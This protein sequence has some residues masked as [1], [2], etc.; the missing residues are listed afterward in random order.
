M[1]RKQYL[2]TLPNVTSDAVTPQRLSA[3]DL[4]VTSAFIQA[5]PG[6]TNRVFIGDDTSQNMALEAGA[7]ITVKGDGLDLGT[8]AIFNLRDVYVLSQVA[9]EGVAISYLE[10]V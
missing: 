7:A 1:A 9:G 10:G 4:W 2:T 3:T 8:T 6:N 5:L